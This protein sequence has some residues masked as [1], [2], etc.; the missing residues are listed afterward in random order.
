MRLPLMLAVCALLCGCL[1][2][3]ATI[4]KSAAAKPCQAAQS[5]AS[6]DGK[7]RDACF[8]S[9]ASG[10]GDSSVCG[11]IEE[12]ESE[13]RCRLAFGEYDLILCGGIGNISVRDE[14]FLNGARLKRDPG[15]CDRLSAQDVRDM[16]RADVAYRFGN[17]SVCNDIKYQDRRNFCFAVADHDGTICDSLANS[18]LRVECV[19]WTMK[20]LPR[21]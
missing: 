2:G 8:L 7:A 3:D 10:C 14:C 12:R 6:L 21:V 17:R 16:C 19:Q 18:D 4:M 5:C 15:L 11:R 1:G 20:K 13:Y 9:A